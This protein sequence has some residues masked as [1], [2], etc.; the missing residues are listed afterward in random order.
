MNILIKY[1]VKQIPGKGLGMIA[2]ESIKKGETVLEESVKVSA[3]FGGN[4]FH[5]I[6]FLNRQ[7]SML[8]LLDREEFLSLN[9]PEPEGPENKKN[10]RIYVNNTFLD[11]LYLK[12]SRMN[13][14]CK[15]NV[16]LSSDDTIH[17]EIVALRN[18]LAGE[19]ILVSYLRSSALETKSERLEKIKNWKFEC[20]CELCSLGDDESN[21]NDENRIE[22][23]NNLTCIDSFFDDVW[24]KPSMLPEVVRPLIKSFFTRAEVT[25]AILCKDLLGE[26]SSALMSTYL[27]MAELVA[28]SESEKFKTTLADCHSSNEFMDLARGEAILLGKMFLSNCKTTEREL[29]ELHEEFG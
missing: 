7:I 20:N 21:K 2:T 19:E 12:G 24:R 28:F 16:M 1:Q 26:S 27:K 13:H 14:S 23:R 17:A 22:V 29:K 8:T 15:P 3:R 6:D 25:L 11:G 18:I 4:D 10:E 9:D 5:S